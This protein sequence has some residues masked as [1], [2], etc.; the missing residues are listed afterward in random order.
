M[1][2]AAPQPTDARS[3][4]GELRG[5]LQEASSGL[6]AAYLASGNAAAMLRGRSR[7]VDGTLR[8]MWNRL[9]MPASVS[10]VAV[11]GYG[12]AELYPHSDVDLLLLVPESMG[13]TMQAQLEQF[14]GL[15]WD[16]GLDIGHAVRTGQECLVEAE[17][18]ITIQSSLLEARHLAG[19]R[20]Q[21]NDF[22]VELKERVD[23]AAFFNA[24]RLEQEERYARYND[25]AYALEPNCKESPGGL[26]DLHNVLWICRAAGIASTWNELARRGLVTRSEAA[27]LTRIEN[28]LRNLRV[29]L[30]LL[31][32]RRED[33]LIFDHQEALAQSCGCAATAARRASEVLMQR[34]Y[35]NAKAVTQLNTILLQ[36]LGALLLMGPEQEAQI[37][38]ER[39]QIE[40]ELLDV[41]SED[42]FERHPPAILE[43]FLLLQR[44][45]ELG[46]MSA[47]TLRALWRARPRIDAEFRRNPHNRATFLDL[48]RQPRGLIHEVRRMNQW[49]ILGRYLPA[50]SRIVGQMQHDLFHVYTVDQHILQVVRNLRRFNMPEF[51]HEYPLCSRLITAFERP[52]VLY[53]AALFHDIAKGRG[54][55]HSQLGKRD[56]LR[57]CRDHALSDEDSDLVVFLVEHHLSFSAVAQKQDLSDPEVIRRVAVLVGNERRLIA[58]YLLT[59]AD[60]RGTSPKVWN[61]W[62]G[63]LL[64]DLFLATQQLLQGA[65][66]HQAL[67][68]DRR[69]QEAD[70]LLRYYGLRPDVEAALWLQLDTAY[71][72]RHD[73]E[74]IAWHA[75]HLYHR[76]QS[77]EPVV[78]ARLSP[79]GEGL[80]V[81]VYVPDQPELFV[82]LC[83]FF[84]RLG[85][86]IADAKIHTTRHGYALDSFVL[87]DP[88]NNLN[89][90][91]TIGLIEHDL[92]E[93]LRTYAPPDQPGSGRLSRQVKHFPISPE[94]NIRP[95]ER[96]NHHVMS[97]KAADRTGLLF[98]VAQVLARHQIDVYAAK[99]ATLGERVEDTFLLSGRELA[100]T[101]TLLR[102]EQ[103][104]LDVLTV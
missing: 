35:R 40:R 63:K 80:Q 52:W 44:H 7:L 67:G 16:I 21:F 14:I 86:S 93:R 32:G 72:M 74:E 65:T 24:K 98:S 54:G 33:R 104:L 2:S 77:A 20:R 39:F 6:R 101:S 38:N 75:R 78:K 90:R 48:F 1:A 71:F 85:Y 91:D 55:D 58:L 87:L 57:F 4:I 45:P 92:V 69:Q 60:I 29:R 83:G 30:H 99:I 88:M 50:F 66:P 12:R 31:A 84:A 28:F 102:L 8:E 17:R 49:G 22:F 47:R 70:R 13:A 73:A 96:G 62:K 3:L 18:D 11:G 100:K 81:M 89:Y 41:R 56:A 51:A 36:N 15:S 82:R 79:I 76:P 59:H 5:R 42:V 25:T 27:H 9:G 26:R 46:G 68:L 97:I 34:Y 103:E 53:I 19:G 95:D 10:L 43:S 94:V 23:P 37:I 61:A 64:E